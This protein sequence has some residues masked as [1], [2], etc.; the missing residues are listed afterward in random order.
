MAPEGSC[1]QRLEV[2]RVVLSVTSSF[3]TGCV[4]C[5]WGKYIEVCGH[6]WPGFIGGD[7]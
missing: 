1:P 6:T 4:G 7:I 2:V 3:R 5:F